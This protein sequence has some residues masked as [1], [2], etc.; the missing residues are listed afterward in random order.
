M[1][2]LTN[3]H[4]FMIGLSGDARLG[5]YIAPIRNQPPEIA[6]LLMATALAD[7][8]EG[9]NPHPAHELLERLQK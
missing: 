3:F 8:R 1:S 9:N 7:S 2:D 4:D 5:R 6:I